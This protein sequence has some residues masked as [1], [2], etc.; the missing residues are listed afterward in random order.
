MPHGPKRTVRLTVLLTV[1]LMTGACDAAQPAPPVTQSASGPTPSTSGPDAAAPSPDASLV[2][3]PAPADLRDVNWDDV[4]VPGDFCG[5]PGLVPVDHTGDATAT[6]RTWG[7]VR[8]TRTKNIIYGDTDGDGRDEAVVFVGC[9]DNG[10]TQNEGTAVAYAV[11][12]HVGK[13][14][15]VLGSMTPRQKT[16]MYHTR[17]V[18]AEFEPG[19]IIVHEKWYRAN[20]AHCCPSG[21]ATT[22]WTRD[23]NRL[24][25]GA[26]RV[27]S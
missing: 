26:P 4:P 12:A 15:A 23:G 18:G 25:P 21:D 22:V 6:S 3:G 13:N 16:V 11:Y 2:V 19:R 17:L 1:L 10:A 14:L 5:I 20:D 7:P 27:T 8:V 24:E 9:D